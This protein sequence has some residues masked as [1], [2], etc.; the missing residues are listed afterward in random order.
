MKNGDNKWGQPPFS[1]PSPPIRKASCVFTTSVLTEI[2]MGNY[3]NLLLFSLKLNNQ[4]PPFGG[5]DGRYNSIPACGRYNTIS[6]CVTILPM[7][8]LKCEARLRIVP[9][10]QFWTLL[11]PLYNRKEAT[12]I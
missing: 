5:L 12:S 3:L 2:L 1:T 11:E 4:K 7:S 9:C 6:P 8:P 10:A